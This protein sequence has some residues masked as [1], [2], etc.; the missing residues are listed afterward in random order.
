MATQYTPR[1]DP[2]SGLGLSSESADPG[3]ST[4]LRGISRPLL[5]ALI[6]NA[7]IGA[8]IL[9]LPG[10]AY[11]I[12]GT[13]SVL[14]WVLCG[15]LTGA[16]ALCFA[17]VGSR[18]TQTGG[19]YL[20]ARVAFE[21]AIGFIVGWVTWVNRPLTIAVYRDVSRGE[22][23]VLTGATRIIDSRQAR[24]AQRSYTNHGYSADGRREVHGKLRCLVD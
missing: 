23:A 10:R 6:V 24:R 15:I 18:F 11:A 2:T 3:T 14:A 13:W 16:V 22:R 1:H 21:P 4:L 5:V 20:Y 7:I 17:E 19:P 8:G 9:G 12:A